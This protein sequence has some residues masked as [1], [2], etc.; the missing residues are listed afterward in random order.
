MKEQD[1]ADWRAQTPPKISRVICFEIQDEHG[2]ASWES[3]QEEL[4]S[5][6]DVPAGPEASLRSSSVADWLALEH[7]RDTGHSFIPFF[8][9]GC[10]DGHSLQNH[11]CSQA[12]SEATNLL[13]D[14]VCKG[15]ASFNEIDASL[16][17]VCE[18]C[19]CCHD[20]VERDHK[21]HTRRL[22]REEAMIKKTGSARAELSAVVYAFSP[23]WNP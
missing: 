3:V 13:V 7:T 1:N 19:G 8:C 18:L 10:E 21:I 4:G 6:L 12:P 16:P 17:P 11:A 5:V 15:C 20:G 9:N 14:F 23:K 2:R 22:H